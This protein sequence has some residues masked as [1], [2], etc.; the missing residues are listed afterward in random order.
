MNYQCFIVS[1][2][3]R[4]PYRNYADLYTA[5]KSYS[6]GGKITESTWAIITPDQYTS[7][8]IRDALLSKIDLN[9]RLLVIRSGKSAAWHHLLADNEWLQKYLAM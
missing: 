4:A 3:L 5:L 8:Q 7:V 6:A 2:D 9:D 1:Y